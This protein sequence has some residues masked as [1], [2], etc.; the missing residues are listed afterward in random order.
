[1]N[2]VSCVDKEAKYWVCLF[3]IKCLAIK[4]TYTYTKHNFVKIYS[5]FDT[6]LPLLLPNDARVYGSSQLFNNLSRR[7]YQWAT[8]S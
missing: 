4:L 6:H 1:M 3:I 7:K 2:T 8:E 5:F